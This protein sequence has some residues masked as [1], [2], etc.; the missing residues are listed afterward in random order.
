MG[1]ST[2]S[3][4][5]LTRLSGLTAAVVGVALVIWVVIGLVGA[6][7][8]ATDSTDSAFAGDANAV[9]AESL[10][11][12][13]FSSIPVNAVLD[14]ASVLIVGDSLVKQSRIDI[15][16]AM[17]EAGAGLVTIVAQNGSTIGWAASEI[18]GQPDHDIVIVASG[19]NNS[20]LGWNEQNE[21]QI[22]RVLT[23]TERFDCKVWM[24]P[25]VW[26]HP[27]VD[28]QRQSFVS[29]RAVN[30]VMGLRTAATVAGFHLAEWDSIA[31]SA[32]EV[33]IDDGLHHNLA[34]YEAYGRFMA[35]E[36]G[37]ACGETLGTAA[38]DADL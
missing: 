29:P 11:A 6:S 34:G 20:H 9:V 5:D 27:L 16:R 8:L 26:R 35:A 23:L 32:I 22:Q 28:G 18:N 36:T 17:L 37:R 14:G 33:H 19:T 4:R 15:R 25:S 3:A 10:T 31:A 24:V 12:Q 7:D 30:L 13:S 2:R 21:R 1:T 38:A